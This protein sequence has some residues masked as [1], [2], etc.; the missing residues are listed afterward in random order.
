[1]PEGDSVSDLSRIH[2]DRLVA[3]FFSAVYSSTP[4]FAAA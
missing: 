3:A 2:V 4:S 1:M